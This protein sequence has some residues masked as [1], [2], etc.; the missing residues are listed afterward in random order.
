MVHLQ[1]NG[2]EVDAR[3]VTENEL[4][5]LKADAGVS[6]ALESCHTAVVDSYVIE[7]HVPADVLDRL[8]AEHPD[9]IAGLAAPGMPIGSPGMD[10]PNPEHYDVIA[11]DGHGG[12]RIY[13]RRWRESASS[14]MYPAEPIGCAGRPYS[15]VAVPRVARR[16]DLKPNHPF[17]RLFCMIGWHPHGRSCGGPD[18]RIEIPG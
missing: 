12:T 7:G 3:D 18:E 16:P 11:F 9:S 14:D 5:A 17:Q 10:G 1:E 8:L 6:R 15:F 13:E 4:V 2:F